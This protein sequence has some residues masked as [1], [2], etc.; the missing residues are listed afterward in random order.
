MKLKIFSTGIKTNTESVLLLRQLKLQLQSAQIKTL[1][2]FKC[3]QSFTFLFIFVNWNVT[4]T[5]KS[6]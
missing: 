5:L 2:G 6:E 3:K 1:L 4:N